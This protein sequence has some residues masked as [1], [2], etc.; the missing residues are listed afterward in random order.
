MSSSATQDGKLGFDPFDPAHRA[1]PYPLYSRLRDEAP[2]HFSSRGYWVFSRH[3]DCLAVLRD[4]RFGHGTGQILEKNTFRRP[5]QGRSKPFILL[6][7]PE[8]TRLRSLVSKAFTRR[9]VERL[10]PRIEEIV[11]DMIG[12]AVEQGE[13][14]LMEALA[15]PLPVTVIS[16]LLGVPKADLDAVKELSSVV[17]RGVDPDHHHTPEE[18]RRRGEAFAAFDAYFR[19]LLGER[20]AHPTGDLLSELAAAGD[21]DSALTDGELLTTC[22]LLYVAGHETTMSLLGNGVLALIRHPEQFAALRARPELAETAVEEFLRY[23]PPTQLSRRTTLEEVEWDG[24]SIKRGDQVVVLRAAANRDP[25]VFAGP[26]RLDL[27]RQDNRHLAFEGG[28]HFCLGASLAR[29]EGRI[30][31]RALAGR[32]RVLELATGRLRYR[33]NLVIRSLVDLPVR[34]R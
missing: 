2:I 25:E 13:V 1:D 21:S 3:R 17:A 4:H 23:D 24:H 31:F 34:L 15:Y 14:D 22:I 26:D 8:H 7:P 5:V 19:V 28:I 20:R 11:A 27:A 9:M 29:L 10:A 12:T 33:D 16:E 6:D 30:A 18:M 32:A